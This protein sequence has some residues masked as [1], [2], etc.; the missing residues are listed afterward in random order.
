MIC[1][2][3]YFN[4]GFEF[5]YSVWTGCHNFSMLS[6]N[7]SDKV[8]AKFCRRKS[9]E[10]VL[11]AKKD[12]RKLDTTNLDLP[13]GFKI[14]INQFCALTIVCFGQQAK[15]YMERAESLVSIF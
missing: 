12:L 1:H 4:H 8:I 2:Y 13:E 7:I 11:K 9:C 14:F 5:Q 15:K 3:F 6:C 10:K